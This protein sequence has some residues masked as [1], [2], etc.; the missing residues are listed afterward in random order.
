MDSQPLRELIPIHD[1]EEG[2]D[3]LPTAD[4]VGHR[5]Q[6]HWLRAIEDTAVFGATVLFLFSIIK[7]LS[8]AGF[9]AAVGLI[10]VSASGTGNILS[11]TVVILAPYLAAVVAFLTFL[12]S[13]KSE[14]HRATTW[15]IAA[16]VFVLAF[17][18]AP[19]FGFVAALV[20]SGLSLLMPH[21]QRA[22]IRSEQRLIKDRSGP[23]WLKKLMS[24]D[25]RGHSGPTHQSSAAPTIRPVIVLAVALV[26]IPLSLS[27]SMWV[28]PEVIDV[29]GQPV[30]AHV[31]EEDGQWATLLVFRPHLKIDSV[32]T[33]QL[34]N[35][36]LCERVANPFEFSST[37][38]EWASNLLS[39]SPEVFAV[40]S[41]CGNAVD[42]R[43]IYV[44]LAMLRLELR[45]VAAEPSVI[46][47][48]DTIVQRA[49]R[50]AG[51]AGASKEL[52]A[53]AMPELTEGIFETALE[54]AN[55]SVR[56]SFC[57]IDRSLN[58]LW[59]YPLADCSS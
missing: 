50:E 53:T 46:I 2:S 52:I 33:V 29:E 25:H 44:E 41:E 39:D 59:R 18:I 11:G 27:P 47:L 30:A 3:S 35:R 34:L 23:T 1:A 17:L 51:G 49:E 48:L 43:L 42:L 9:D 4:P 20:L 7:V 19:W 55:R 13:A 21:I 10:L 56:L 36:E 26:A 54:T 12:W 22:L 16:L 45:R 14:H 31:L 28:P 38:H 57:R 8:A 40:V 6:F 58:E 15:T 32:P 24:R 37:A 5:P